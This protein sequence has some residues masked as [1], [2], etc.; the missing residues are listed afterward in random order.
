MHSLAKFSCCDKEVCVFP[1]LVCISVQLL[2]CRCVRDEYP[3]LGQLEFEYLQLNFVK[4]YQLFKNSKNSQL[5]LSVR[6][7][8]R[9]IHNVFRAILI[10]QPVV[11]HMDLH[12]PY[13]G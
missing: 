5:P 6:L 9:H 13:D 10:Q 1:D 3:F 4:A 7:A 8:W 2:F 11:D 12:L